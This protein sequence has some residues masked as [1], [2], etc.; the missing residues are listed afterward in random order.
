MNKKA[1]LPYIILALA[2]VVAA[3]C[4]YLALT[5]SLRNGM[6]DTER[7]EA[8]EQ[9]CQ[10][11]YRGDMEQGVRFTGD[12]CDKAQLDQVFKTRYGYDYR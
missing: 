1:A 9:E 7:Y 5:G 6:S 12:P 11:L 3:I 2:A 4:V 10:D 8:I